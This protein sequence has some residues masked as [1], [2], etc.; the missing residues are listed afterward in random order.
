ML[1]TS[2]VLSRRRCLLEVWA[3]RFGASLC[4]L[5]SARTQPY[6]PILVDALAR[7]SLAVIFESVAIRWIVF[8][9]GDITSKRVLPAILAEPRSLLAGI[10]TR[11][12]AKASPYGVPAWTSL[13]AAL[14]DQ[15]CDAVYVASPVVLHA[16]VY[17]QPE[18]TTYVPQAKKQ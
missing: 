3:F 2:G 8:G 11:T 7:L 16:P 15:E 17:H 14:A 18:I 1:L 13:E 10:V 5:R 6:P 12:P 9:V 4:K